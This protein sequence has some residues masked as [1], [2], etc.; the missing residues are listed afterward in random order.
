MLFLSYHRCACLQIFVVLE[1]AFVIT[2][3]SSMRIIVAICGSR[4]YFSHVCHIIDAHFC[5]YLWYSSSLLSFWS[6]HRCACLPLFVVLELMFVMSVMSS[7]H[8]CAAICNTRAHFCH[9]KQI[10]DADFPL[11]LSYSSS[12]LSFQSH[13]RCACLPLFV[14]L[15]PTFAI[16]IISSMRICCCY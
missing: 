1:P 6:H 15:E 9:L 2:V 10:I 12:L 3:I 11:N 16:L 4:T 14:V 13:H 5:S 7:L 8:I